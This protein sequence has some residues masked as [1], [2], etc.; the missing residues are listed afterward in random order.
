MNRLEVS[1]K[2]LLFKLTRADGDCAAKYLADVE[3]VRQ[4][5]FNT[6]DVGD[7][8]LFN[9]EVNFPSC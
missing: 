1:V 4:S 7:F 8:V 5:R 2:Q 3:T 9:P 6:E